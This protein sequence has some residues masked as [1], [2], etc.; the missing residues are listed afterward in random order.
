MFTI[1]KRYG[2]IRKDI[3]LPLKKTNICCFEFG[4]SHAWRKTQGIVYPFVS[5]WEDHIFLEYDWFDPIIIYQ[6]EN[7]DKRI[8]SV[9][10]DYSYQ[11]GTYY[12]TRQGQTRS[13]KWDRAP[14]KCMQ[15]G[16]ERVAE[17]ETALNFLENPEWDYLAV[18]KKSIIDQIHRKLF[19]RFF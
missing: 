10:F 12:V 7:P 5:R 18:N 1:P 2:Y 19:E 9:Q 3:N 17:D 14:L 8:K 13:L 16:F 4:L 6:D 11:Q 15:Y